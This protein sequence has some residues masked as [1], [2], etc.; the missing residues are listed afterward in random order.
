M[1]S[2]KVFYRESFPTILDRDARNPRRH[3]R[4][5]VYT[6]LTNIFCLGR[7]WMIGCV[8]LYLKGPSLTVLANRWPPVFWPHINYQV[9]LSRNLYFHIQRYAKKLKAMIKCYI[10]WLFCSQRDP[11]GSKKEPSVCWKASAP[12][13]SAHSFI[14]WRYWR[15]GLA[16]L[17]V[18]WSS[19]GFSCLLQR[20]LDQKT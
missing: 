12:H 18:T 1:Q 10:L 2:R 8:H 14:P 4:F 20:G 11:R 6:T 15:W 13:P 9:S 7:F 16:G 3:W 19:W 17:W 5:A